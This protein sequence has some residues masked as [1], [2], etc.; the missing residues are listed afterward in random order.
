MRMVLIVAE[1]KYFE[2]GYAK[3]RKWL[4]LCGRHSTLKWACDDV[5]ILEPFQNVVYACE[6]P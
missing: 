2:K 3:G 4:E 6:L 5:S 1:F